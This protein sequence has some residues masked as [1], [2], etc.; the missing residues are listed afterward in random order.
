MSIRAVPAPKLRVPMLALAAF[1]VT[2]PSYAEADRCLLSS[3]HAGMTFPMEHLERAS[4]CRLHPILA[5]HTT[6][7]KVGPIRTPLPEPIYVYL[8]DHP[9]VAAML[10]NRLDLG[11]YQVE[12]RGPGWYWGND[13]EGAEGLVELVYQD[14][15][16]RMYY[17]EGSYESRLL[18]HLTGKAVVLLSMQPVK[19]PNGTEAMDT[20]MVTY[21][22]LDNRVLSGIVSLLRPLVGGTVTRKLVKGVDTVNRL[23]DVMRR[24]ADRVLFEATD[25]PG[26]PEDQV[27]VL[28]EALATLQ[29]PAAGRHKMAAP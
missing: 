12:P 2:T 25:P 9:S 20:T 18:P 21:T 13:G 7:N 27:A 6:A 4:A 17:L 26:L 23:S 22:R 19:E 1:I 15:T 10:I 11:L 5:N 24:A 8:L 28:K 3:Q 29:D 16:N 14:R